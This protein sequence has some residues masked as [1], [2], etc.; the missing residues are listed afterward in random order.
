MGSRKLIGVYDYTVILTYLGML[1]SVAAIL[2]SVNEDYRYAMIFLM[3]AGLCDMFDGPVAR[4]KERTEAEKKFGIQIDS[5]SDLISFGVMPAIFVYIR[6]GKSM[7]SGTLAS[8]Y[9]LAALIRLAFYNVSEEERQQQTEEKRK[10]FLGLPV[11]TIAVLLPLVYL[12]QAS[13]KIPHTGFYQLLLVICGVAFLTP[14]QIKKP[15]LV[16][17]VCLVALGVL[18]FAGILFLWRTLA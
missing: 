16:G 13:G 2:L 5:F 1:C 14:V 12:L 9:T 11:T 6:T 10:A 3:L 8:L 7:V 18:E 4:T 15:D 17:K